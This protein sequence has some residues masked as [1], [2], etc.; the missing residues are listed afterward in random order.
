[1]ASPEHVDALA[2]EGFGSGAEPYDRGRPGYP[3][4]AVACLCVGLDIGEASRVLDLGAGT[5]KLGL[6]IRQLSGAEVI[7]LEPVSEMRAIAAD[8][9]LSVVDGTAERIPDAEASF[10]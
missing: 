4:A 3:P 2:A 8:H 10:D 5:G 9:G 7:G 1:M 6:A